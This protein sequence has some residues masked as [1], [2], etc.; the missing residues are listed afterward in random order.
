MNQFR[1]FL[2]R[3]M[4]NLMAEGVVAREVG[5]RAG[6]PSPVEHHQKQGKELHPLVVEEGVMI[7]M[8]IITTREIGAERD[9]ERVMWREIRVT[10]KIRTLMVGVRT[11]ELGMSVK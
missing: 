11:V 6:A 10:R 5:M 4:E 7:V 9:L 1:W 2:L 3:I 8:R